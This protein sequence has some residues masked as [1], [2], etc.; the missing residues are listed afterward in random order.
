MMAKGLISGGVQRIWAELAVAVTLFSVILL[1]CL[2]GIWSRPAGLLASVWPANA[3]FLGLLLRWPAA[4][5][6][7]PLIGAV[8]AFV[9]ADLLSGAGLG[10]ALGLNATNLASI[11]IAYAIL[12]PLPVVI[13]RL[14]HPAS[15]VW[16]VVAS[17]LGGFAAALVGAVVSPASPGERLLA[18]LTWAVSEA[19]NYLALLPVILAAPGLDW[20][21]RRPLRR[22][23]RKSDLMPAA[24][25]VASC[26]FALWIGGPGAVAVPV[27]ALLWCGMV[28][29]VFP[30]TLLT[31]FFGS[32][33]LSVLA[34]PL[35]LSG[36]AEADRTSLISLRFGVAMIALMPVLLALLNRSRNEMT[37]RLHHLAHH[38][39][40]TGIRNRSAFIERAGVA[41]AN[42]RAPLA[43]MAIDLDHFKDVNDSWGHAAGDTVLVETVRRISDLLR[44]SDHF[45]RLGGEEFAVLLPD[46]SAEAGQA[47]AER[48]RRAVA[49]KPIQI[50]GGSE[51]SVT[52]SIGLVLIAPPSPLTLAGALALADRCLYV[53]KGEG[54]NR[55]VI[56][57]S[58]DAILDAH[59]LDPD[60]ERG[61]D[62]E[63]RRESRFGGE[64]HGEEMDRR[65]NSAES[66]SAGNPNDANDIKQAERVGSCDTQTPP[67]LQPRTAQR[68]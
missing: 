24:S 8:S 25:V 22:L 13:R 7:M 1:S 3:V 62:R 18:V 34:E 58:S 55:V 49:A 51:I 9:C 29:P 41:L 31:L 64:S 15:L 52:I 54:R 28:Y 56:A 5:R 44:S 66:R 46:C 57:P 38:D 4:G 53:A 10:L 59:L 19:V 47:I 37:A 11:G 14:R 35:V 65:Q 2:I 26:L 40:L 32:F 63:L 48:L 30:T 12:A 43:L 17:V 67:E 36:S 16:I 50:G 42:A 23:A 45:A 21:R 27:L 33:A 6:A 68:G 39:G 20:L 61:D 60:F